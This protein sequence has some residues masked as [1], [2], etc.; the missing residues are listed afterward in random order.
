MTSCNSGMDD[1]MFYSKSVCMNSFNKLQYYQSK[2]AIHFL[3]PHKITKAVI[4]HFPYFEMVI[5][6]KK[7]LQYYEYLCFSIPGNTKSQKY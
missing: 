6:M 4:L 7:L 1:F 2:K 3:K 5:I